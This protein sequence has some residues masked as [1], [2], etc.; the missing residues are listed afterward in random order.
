MQNIYD[1]T[2]PMVIFSVFGLAALAVAFMLKREDKRK[3]YG[4]EQP[5]IAN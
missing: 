4:L 3:N 2:L 5:N 1:Y